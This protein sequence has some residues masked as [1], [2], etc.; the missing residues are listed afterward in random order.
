LTAEQYAIS[1]RRKNMSFCVIDIETHDPNLKHW[2]DG[3]VRKDGHI[4]MVGMYDGN[5]AICLPPSDPRV[6][7]RLRDP[8]ITKIFHNG[9]YDLSWLQVGYGF[10]VNGRCEDT[11]TR[12]A[13]L[14]AYAGAYNLEACCFRR[15]VE[16]KN[17]GD[18][19]DRWWNDHGHKGK[20]IEHLNEMPWEVVE[21]YCKQDLMATWDLFHAQQPILEK[22]NLL[23]VNDLE[24]RLYPILMEMKGNGIR[25]D[26]DALVQLSDKLNGEY[27]TGMRGLIQKYPYL[28]S[29]GA[30]TQLIKVFQEENIPLV[31]PE[32]KQKPS[33]AHDVLERIDHPVIKEI[34]R[35]KQ[36]GTVLNKFVDGSYPDY[37]VN[38]RIHGTVIPMLRDEGG[39]MTGRM[40]M[41]EP[42][43]Q[44]APSRGD[45]YAKEIR[46][47]FLPDMDCTLAAFDYKQIE[48]CVFAHYAKEPGGE[49]LRENMTKGMDYHDYCM[50]MLGWND[51]HLTKNM[52]FGK[53]Y[54]LGVKSFAERFY[55][56]LKKPAEEMG[57]SVRDYAEYKNAEYL[58][59]LSFIEPTVRSIQDTG[60]TRG[61]VRTI[62]GRR[63]RVPLDNKV[64]KLVNY[65]CSG[66]AADILKAGLVAGWEAGIFDVLVMHFPVHDENVFSIPN[67]K[68]GYE[69]ARE[70]A[71]LMS[72]AVK[73]RVPIR[74][75]TEVGPDWGHCTGENWKAMGEEYA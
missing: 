58:A 49:K 46:S 22:D 4:I 21:K 47:L 48:Y 43:L 7:D 27:E 14:D 18:T 11:M 50:K 12:E 52:G 60:R 41:R 5:E 38:M 70:F 16:G 34:M 74:V 35:L 31:I 64:F 67:T 29:L 37:M 26:W 3:S 69:A 33:F 55:M 68:A 32:G 59:N 63:Q 19:I 56:V 23:H 39:T 8:T 40:S 45:K 15:G 65:L 71:H 75:D 66:G 57:V 2:G 72:T 20:A 28:N 54:G 44:Q 36:I 24:C 25:L 61:Y 30:P 62:M 51:R 53:L 9:V 17:K 73:L 10:E 13:L 42:N 1:G 6:A